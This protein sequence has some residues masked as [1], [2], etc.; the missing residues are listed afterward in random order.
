MN[1]P[2]S[3]SELTINEQITLLKMLNSSDEETNVLAFNILD[4]TKRPGI[5]LNVENGGHLF[6]FAQFVR[7]KARRVHSDKQFWIID[8]RGPDSFSEEE[9]HYK[10]LLERLCKY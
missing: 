7:G 4:N 10:E 1:L 6:S 2:D 8:Y 5:L 3:D 9:I